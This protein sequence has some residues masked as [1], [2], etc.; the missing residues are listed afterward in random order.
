MSLCTLPTHNYPSLLHIDIFDK[1]DHIEEALLPLRMLL[2]KE[3]DGFLIEV[4]E[5]ESKLSISLDVSRFNPEELKVTLNGRIL[6]IEGKQ[7]TNDERGYSMRSFTRHLMLPESA[8]IEKIRSSLT[9]DGKLKIEVPEAVESNITTR[10]IPISRNKT[11]P[12]DYCKKATDPQKVNEE[13]FSSAA[14]FWMAIRETL[15]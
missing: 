2:N 11:L 15:G 8:D 4:K 10:T 9:S 3:E 7:E 5:D 14:G 12:T 6:I 1:L 13:L